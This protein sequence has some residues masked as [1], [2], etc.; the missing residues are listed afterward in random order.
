MSTILDRDVVKACASLGL[1]S[2]LLIH[3]G[4][5]IERALYRKATP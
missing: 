1:A 5:V 4:R 2:V 3:L